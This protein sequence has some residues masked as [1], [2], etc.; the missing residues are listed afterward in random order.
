[1]QVSASPGEVRTPWQEGTI[2][3]KELV[4]SSLLYLE[5]GD[6]KFLWN[7]GIFWSD[8]W[9]HV[10]EHFHV[11]YNSLKSH[12]VNIPWLNENVRVKLIILL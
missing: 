9:L 10:P 8:S 5:D 1:M 4:A 11:Y 3:F 7:V 2:A 12:T 6:S